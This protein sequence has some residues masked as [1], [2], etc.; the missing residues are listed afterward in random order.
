[1]GKNGNGMTFYVDFERI[2]KHG[3]HIYWCDLIDLFKPDKDDDTS[4]KGYR[5]GDCRL[6]RYKCLHSSFHKEPMGGEIGVTVTPKNQEWKYPHA[7]S[8]KEPILKS[9]CSL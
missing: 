3:E 5:Q 2:K 7:N 6:L 1:M 9:V 8:V 4:Y